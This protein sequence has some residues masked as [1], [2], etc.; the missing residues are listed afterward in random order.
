MFQGCQSLVELNIPNFDFKNLPNIQ[1]MFFGCS[2]LQSL[3][4]KNL[5]LKDAKL[6]TFKGCSQE[7]ID[8]FQNNESNDGDEKD[9]CII[10]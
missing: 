3:Y 6:M 7:I 4:A 8:K 1:L 5:K 9:N 2:S 10:V